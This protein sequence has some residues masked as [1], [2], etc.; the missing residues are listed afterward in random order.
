MD[1]RI[2]DLLVPSRPVDAIRQTN[3]KEEDVENGAIRG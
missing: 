3:E 2:R 1:R